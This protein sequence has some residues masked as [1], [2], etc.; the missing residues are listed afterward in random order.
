M[1]WKGI[2]RNTPANEMQEGFGVDAKNGV[3]SELV[4]ATINEGGFTVWQKAGSTARSKYGLPFTL[5]DNSYVRRQIGEIELDLNRFIIISLGYFE[6]LA[7]TAGNRDVKFREIGLINENGEYITIINDF[8]FVGKKLGF[9]AQYPVTGEFT[10]NYL[11]ETIVALTDGNVTPYYINVN[12]YT[13]NLVNGVSVLGTAANF[14]INEILMFPDINQIKTEMTVLDGGGSIE[15]GVYYFT[16]RYVNQDLTVTNPLLTSQP[17]PVYNTSRGN[18]QATY[19]KVEG[20]LELVNTNKSILLD[21]NNVNTAFSE[22]TIYAV[23]KR[24]GV[25]KAVEL[26]TIPITDS[27]IQTIITSS[28]G[29]ADISLAELLIPKATFTKVYAFTQVYNRLYAARPSYNSLRNF[30]KYA[31]TVRLTWVSKIEKPLSDAIS[32]R[33]GF[34]ERTFIH[35]EVYAVNIHLVLNDGTVTEGFHIPWNWQA[36]SPFTAVSALALAQGMQLKQFQIEDTCTTTTPF[37]L[38]GAGGR[39]GFWEN[40]DEYYPNTP[41]YDS[42]SIGGIDFRGKKVRHHRMPSINYMAKGYINAGASEYGKTEIDTLGIIAENVIIPSHIAPFVKSWFLSYA[43]RSSID[44]TVIGQSTVNFQSTALQ[45]LAGTKFYGN[46]DTWSSGLNNNFF[47]ASPVFSVMPVTPYTINRDA[48]YDCNETILRFYDLN[49]LANQPDIAPAYISNEIFYDVRMDF[50]VSN[51]GG[52][53]TTDNKAT[54]S[55]NYITGSVAPAETPL[56]YTGT[57][58]ALDVR[59]R[60]VKEYKYLSNQIIDGRFDNIVQEDSL[61]LVI[62]SELDSAVVIPNGANRATYSSFALFPPASSWTNQYAVDSSNGNL[63]KSDGTT[64]N[65]LGSRTKGL[66]S[67]PVNIN[68]QALGWGNNGSWTNVRNQTYLTTLMSAPSNLYKLIS[69]K[70]VSTGEIVDKTVTT[71][72]TYNGDGFATINSFHNSGWGGTR[73]NKLYEPADKPETLVRNITMS[74]VISQVNNQLRSSDSNVDTKKFWPKY[75]NYVN[76]IPRNQIETNKLYNNDYSSINNL[77]ALQP[78]NNSKVVPTENFFR[79]NRTVLPSGESLDTGWRTW[80]INDYYEAP[81]NKGIIINI[82]GQDRDLFIHTE[83][84]LFKTVGNEQL[85]IDASSAFIGAGNIFER[86]AI[87][88]I[89]SSQGTYGTQHRFSCKLTKFGYVFVDAEY[90][91]IVLVRGTEHSSLSDTSIRRWLIEDLNI[92]PEVTYQDNPYFGKGIHVG[93]DYEYNRLFFTKKDYELT[94]SGVIAVNVGLLTYTEGRWMLSDTLTNT[95]TEIAEDN[96]SYFKNLSWTLVYEFQSSA[97]TFFQDYLPNRFMS[98]RFNSFCSVNKPLGPSKSYISRLFIMNQ[99]NKGIYDNTTKINID[100]V[101]AETATPYD[102]YVVPVF[103][104]GKESLQLIALN[105]VTDIVSTNKL[106]GSTGSYSHET[107]SKLLA[108]NSYQSTDI[109]NIVPFSNN[110][111]N[112]FNYNIRKV[113][114]SWNFDKF[115]DLLATS[116][117]NS[118]QPF[119]NNYSELDTSK[120]DVSKPFYTKLPLIDNWVAVKII[121]TNS[122][123][124]T[125]EIRI[126]QLN[127]SVLPTTR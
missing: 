12:Y 58:A 114:S 125:K 99:P 72:I 91:N 22:L 11:N 14:N 119:I 87:E 43:E 89:P 45:N 5:T 62:D 104:F 112:Y 84:A 8:F 40:N 46:K 29:V 118:G 44:S 34:N 73:S 69:Q 20:D 97:F 24:K 74:L 33:A 7:L 70:L 79:I 120:I 106:I 23:I 110:M 115:F 41:E 25:M 127:I 10:K 32:L 124:N 71:C 116:V 4:G 17:V 38:S 47:L 90:H 3:N 65:F 92:S 50:N 52:G 100:S 78:Y 57:V 16:Y 1:K 102:F 64:W 82:Q 108:F 122:L 27:Y 55:S 76:A 113:K 111:V 54:F 75:T 96:S 42:T 61:I 59:Y 18:S 85:N 35:K 19:D 105:L 101:S 80:L 94:Q 88:Y 53:D 93:V 63:Y 121:Y 126:L 13:A 77:I 30:Q 66:R 56:V 26:T 28:E 60:K 36:G 103:S 51:N 31:N 9:T 107:I 67:L 37:G 15:N 86:P 21:I 109:I 83:K 123:Q 39:L 98:A 2:N 68:Y 81:R 117:Y 95:I 48:N 49:I 6:N